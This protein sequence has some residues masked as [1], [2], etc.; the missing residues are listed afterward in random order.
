M[1]P[2]LTSLTIFEK[3]QKNLQGQKLYPEHVEGRVFFMSMFNDTDW[4]KKG[5][6]EICL[7]NSEKVRDFAKKKKKVPAWTLVIP[8]PRR[9]RKDGTERTPSNLKENGSP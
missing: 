8:R 2:G 9:R 4:S 6:S 7:S 1:F 3:I 5:H